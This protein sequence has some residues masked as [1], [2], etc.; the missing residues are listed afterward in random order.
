M[1]QC[2]N[3]TGVTE[4]RTVQDYLTRSKLYGEV[5][6]CGEFEYLPYITHSGEGTIWLLSHRHVD[7]TL[8]VTETHV[9]NAVRLSRPDVELLHER[10]SA[11]SGD[12]S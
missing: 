5:L 11:F 6:R 12:S 3:V 9:F 7:R 2:D 8:T 1:T 4:Y 10:D